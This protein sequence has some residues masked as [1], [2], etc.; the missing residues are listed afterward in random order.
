MTST[1]TT[2]D[3]APGIED[4][5]RVSGAGTERPDPEVPQRARRRTFTVQYKLET[6]AAYDAA[7]DGEKGAL[8]RREEPSP[9]T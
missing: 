4:P 1:V 8:L 6:L 3:R 7:P 9:K 2:L 5:R